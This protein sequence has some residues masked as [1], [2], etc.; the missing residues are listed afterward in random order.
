MKRIDVLIRRAERLSPPQF[1]VL[2]IL[3]FEDGLYKLTFGF[4]SGNARDGVEKVVSAHK[5]RK[6]ALGECDKQLS[7]F[8]VS[9]LMQPVLIDLSDLMGGEA[10]EQEATAL[11]NSEGSPSSID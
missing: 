2:S 4:W 8:R 7:K 3:S 1:P 6:A 10:D 9:P 11:I 5:T